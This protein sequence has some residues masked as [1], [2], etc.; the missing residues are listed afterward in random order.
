MNCL[1]LSE[2]TIPAS[3]TSIG[4]YAFG[5]KFSLDKYVALSFT[6]KYYSGSAGQTYAEKNTAFSSELVTDSADEIEIEDVPDNGG[7]WDEIIHF[8]L[9]AFIK[10]LISAVITMFF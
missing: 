8:D 6:V 4:G 1:A 10:K 9:I 7:I 5:Y 2:I 3:V